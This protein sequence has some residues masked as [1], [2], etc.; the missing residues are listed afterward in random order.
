MM[1]ECNDNDGRRGDGQTEMKLQPTGTSVYASRE[2]KKLISLRR[3][4]AVLPD[5]GGGT[6]ETRRALCRQM[7]RQ[8][9][10]ENTSNCTTPSISDF[11][12]FL[13]KIIFK[14]I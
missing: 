4:L 6:A 12:Y 9:T 5:Q 2:E 11:Q 1:D 8:M 7:T 13:N 10:W 14:N 3:R